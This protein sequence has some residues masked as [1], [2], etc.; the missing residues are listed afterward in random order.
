MNIIVLM[1]LSAKKMEEELIPLFWARYIKKKY[2][3]S[4]TVLTMDSIQNRELYQICY[5]YGADKVKILSD[6]HFAGADSLATSRTIARAIS[7]LEANYNLILA[8]VSSTFG[9]TSQVP[10][11]VAKFLDIQYGYN[12]LRFDL[13]KDNCIEMEENLMNYSQ[14]SV[15]KLPI[16]MSMSYTIN[17]EMKS[18]PTL[19]DIMMAANKV[20]EVY[21]REDI[22]L[23]ESLCGLKGSRTRVIDG[24]KLEG[25]KEKIIIYND[26]MR[27]I[28][29]INNYIEMV[30]ENGK[31]INTI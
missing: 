7:K 28:K 17:S 15:V 5:S 24:R 25:K 2:N 23:N 27:G 29:K 16:L 12:V 1:R 11:S 6:K 10:I 13:A 26:V 20:I 9:E 21:S 8:G 4:I 31:N 19:Y 14:V 18:R 30:R 3:A 22:E